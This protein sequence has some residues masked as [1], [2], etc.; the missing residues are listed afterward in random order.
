MAILVFQR[1]LQALDKNAVEPTATSDH[2]DEE[3]ALLQCNTRLERDRILFPLNLSCKFVKYPEIYRF[4]SY[5]KVCI[6]ILCDGS[7]KSKE[8]SF[9]VSFSQ[10]Y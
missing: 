4:N 10:I 6:N 8:K 5:L 1:P 7:P 2:G 9:I 3:L